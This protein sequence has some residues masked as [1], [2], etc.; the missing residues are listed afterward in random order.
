MTWNSNAGTER[1][2][3]LAPF[4]PPKD[5]APGSG[6]V[7]EIVEYGSYK[8]GAEIVPSVTLAHVAQREVMPD[9]RARIVNAGNVTVSLNKALRAALRE[10]EVPVGTCVQIEFKGKSDDPKLNGMFLYRVATVPGDYLV[11]VLRDSVKIN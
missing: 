9:G 11:S 8:A 2:T 3:S 5:A 4:W 6:I 10:I 7:G 1:D